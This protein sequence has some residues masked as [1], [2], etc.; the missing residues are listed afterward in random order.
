VAKCEG[1]EPSFVCKADQWFM[2][3]RRHA[4]DVTSAGAELWR[5]FSA[6]VASDEVYFSTVLAAVGAIDCSGEATRSMRRKLR[7]QLGQPPFAA[8]ER[9]DVGDEVCACACVCMCMC[10]LL[11]VYLGA[12]ACARAL[13]CVSTRSDGAARDRCRGGA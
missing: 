13:V 1:M 2:L 7:M 5:G 9:R 3:T 12:C 8:D 11:C 6:V 4:L 10:V